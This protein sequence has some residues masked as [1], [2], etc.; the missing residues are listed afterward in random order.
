MAN[1]VAVNYLIIGLVVSL[2]LT[3]VYMIEQYYSIPVRKRQEGAVPSSKGRVY[4]PLPSVI[5]YG[6]VK[7][8]W[9]RSQLTKF[10]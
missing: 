10:L 1:N 4:N 7:V 9:V 5:R 8:A 2:F 3:G 6:R